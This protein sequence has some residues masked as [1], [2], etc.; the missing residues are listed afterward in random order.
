MTIE[1]E[2]KIRVSDEP[3]DQ[4]VARRRASARLWTLL[5]K[6]AAHP[7]VAIILREFVRNS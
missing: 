7:C 3:V 1:L 5:D 4:H 6:I 2:I